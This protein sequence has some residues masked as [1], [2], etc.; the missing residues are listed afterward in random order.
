VR[1]IAGL[2]AMVAVG[3][4]N[5]GGDGRPAPQPAA[6]P[7]RDD[8]A[9]CVYEPARTY[10]VGVLD[11]FTVVDAARD[12]EVDVRVRYP[13]GRDDPAPVVVF[14]HG[15]GP[16][17]RGTF[18]NDAWGETLASA[19]YVVVHLNH[20]LDRADFVRACS[21][22]GLLGRGCSIV[23]AT[24][25]LRPGDAAVVLGSLDQI[26]GAF[27]E[28]DGRVDTATV[29]MAGHSF[30]AYTTMTVAGARVDLGPQLPDASFADPTPA[31]FLAL[32]PQGPGRLGFTADSWRDLDRPVMT[33]SGA[34]DD[35]PA[36]Q[37]EERRIPF[38]RMPPGDKFAVWLSDP[39]ATHAT[40][41]LSNPGEPEL[42]SWVA[43]AALAFLDA[44]LT[45]DPVAEA[46]L[47]GEILQRASRGVAE[48]DEK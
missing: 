30:G 14:S 19:G 22:I 5:A 24:Q 35:T 38:E 41:N 36:E 4:C 1:V 37:A 18:G 21:A 40:F 20:S 16:R 13:I 17:P 34:G 25:W 8:S 39:A 29:A 2:F 31:A 7:C 44:Q 6:G 45:G 11:G 10:D 42:E 27:P 23:A 12:R 32:S 43:A 9:V 46:W 48:V 33:V 47:S 3:S 26:V 28:L 15:G